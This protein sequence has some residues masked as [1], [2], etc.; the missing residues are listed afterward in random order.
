MKSLLAST[1]DPLQQKKA[2]KAE[3]HGDF[4]FEAVARDWHKKMSVSEC[5]IAIA[6]HSERILNSLT[7]HPFPAILSKKNKHCY[8]KNLGILFLH[9]QKFF[10]KQM[11]SYFIRH[12]PIITIYL[13]N[14]MK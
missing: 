9:P 14:Q 6:Q 8:L 10:I 1:L 4:T 12:V 3:V 5:W 2:V 13:Y 7:N 11:S